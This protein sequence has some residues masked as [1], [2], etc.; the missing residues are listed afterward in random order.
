MRLMLLNVRLLKELAI[1]CSSCRYAG[2]ALLEPVVVHQLE[3]PTGT[4]AAPAREFN[5][6]SIRC[7]LY[8]STFFTIPFR[9]A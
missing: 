9:T 6:C 5:R 4:I 8:M 3:V 7:R 1:R 2:C